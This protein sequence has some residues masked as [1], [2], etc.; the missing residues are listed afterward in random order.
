M[1]D[2]RCIN[3]R[4]L[5]QLVCYDWSRTRYLGGYPL[6]LSSLWIHVEVCGCQRELVKVIGKLM[7]GRC[8]VEEKKYMV[9]IRDV[10]VEGF[11]KRSYFGEGTVMTLFPMLPT[12][13][14]L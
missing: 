9:C 14:N 10:A 12:N 5:G 6:F 13:C 2:P 4:Y 1:A 11:H 7:R 8:D 3:L